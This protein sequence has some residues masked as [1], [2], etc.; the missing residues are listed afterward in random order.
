MKI[1][2]VGAGIS[3]LT[4]AAAMHQLS[5][6]T[7]VELF[8]RDASNTSRSQGYGLGLKGDGGLA[9]LKTLCLYNQLAKDAVTV[10]NFV[11]LNQRGQP[12]L[13][14]PA[15][16]DEKRLTLRIKR[17]ALKDALWAAAPNAPT[18]FGK[19]CTG[20]QTSSDGAI[21]KFE[22][23]KT[24][25]YDY[26]IACDGVSSAIRQQM[27]ADERRY[28]GLVAIVG[29]TQDAIRH[30]L[31]DGGY[32]MTLGDEGSSVFCYRQND[33]VHLSYAVHVESE[34]MLRTL[35]SEALL[36]RIQLA[37]Q[38]WHAP[39]PAI[40]AAIDPASIVVRGC[41]DKNP[42]RHIRDGRVWLIGDAAHPMSPFQGQ[43][44]NMGMVDGLKLAQLFAADANTYETRAAT[45]EADM[46]ARGRKAV[47]ESRSAAKQFH[48]TSYLQQQFRNIGFRIGNAVIRLSNR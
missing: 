29:E 26:A 45:L 31:I 25:H 5:P 32:F 40:A 47:L 22:S 34:Q 2:V 6:D 37:T 48:S 23:G 15:T 24:A 3:G 7:T 11:F 19:R 30:P 10:T 44:A 43:G 21:L 17:Q 8:E 38:H 16:G 27:L 33:G 46:V 39:I 42:T 13:A 20:Y 41:Y 1:G 12:M 36:K 4:F 18:H 28:L 14:L 35:T 9:V